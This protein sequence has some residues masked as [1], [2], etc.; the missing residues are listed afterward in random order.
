MYTITGAT[1]KTGNI[2]A[3]YYRDAVQKKN[4]IRYAVLLS[5]IG[6]HLRKGAE[7]L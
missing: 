7:R 6:A 5:S 2:V 4:N 3:R 1:G